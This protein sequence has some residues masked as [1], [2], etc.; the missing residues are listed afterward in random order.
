MSRFDDQ[1]G[2]PLLKF[3]NL[4]GVRLETA[5]RVM[6]QDIT[7]YMIAF[8]VAILVALVKRDWLGYVAFAEIFVAVIW[9]GIRLERRETYLQLWQDQRLVQK[10][11][12]HD[13]LKDL[14]DFS[15]KLKESK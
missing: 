6:F 3:R 15:K 13:N 1:Y 12:V 8:V 2:H 10:Q 9:A 11:K 14:E 7:A 5:K 4:S